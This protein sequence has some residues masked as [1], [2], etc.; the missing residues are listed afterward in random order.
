[1]KPVL[2]TLVFAL[3]CGLTAVA[4]DS[5]PSTTPK[6][7]SGQTAASQTAVP[8]AAA[9]EKL[10]PEV[11]AQKYVELWNTGNVD[12]V[13]SIFVFPA[14]MTSRGFTTSLDASR[15]K[16]VIANWR[17]SMP[18]LNFKVEDTIVQGNKV[19]MR[20]SFTGTYKQ[21]LFPNTADPKDAPRKLRA[22]A[23]WI[24][25]I[26]DGK[27]RNV[28]EEYD[29]IRMRYAMGG[30]WRSNEEL[31]AAAKASATAPQPAPEPEPSQASPPKP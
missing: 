25:E 14:T 7:S 29:E 3:F 30:F 9:G 24:F 28:W 18:D 21:R 27:I 10:S 16:K 8:P 15:L 31:E 1:V 22:S 2:A 5:G 4:Q 6:A 17:R 26:K 12:P 19:A 11:L 13:N 20:L 23:M